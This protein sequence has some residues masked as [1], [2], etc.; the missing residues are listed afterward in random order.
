M[1]LLAELRDLGDCRVEADTS[2]VPPLATL[3]PTCCCITWN[4]ELWTDKPRSIIEDVFIFI[5]D[6]MEL[7]IREVDAASLVESGAETPVAELTVERQP[8]TTTAAADPRSRQAGNAHLK[9]GCP[10]GRES[11]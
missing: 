6:D 8:V 10:T 7:D 2:E 11:E 1:A 9:R 3:A 5:I 4:V